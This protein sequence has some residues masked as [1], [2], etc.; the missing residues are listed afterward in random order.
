MSVPTVQSV[1]AE[2]SAMQAGHSSRTALGAARHRAVHQV[3]ERGFIFSDPFALPILGIS[4]DAIIQD[5]QNDEF[6]RK[7]RLFIAIRSR[8]A[9][10]AF[11]TAGPLVERAL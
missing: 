2:D 6:T 4:A 8:L 7:L 11:T 1:L 10:D 3:L 9:E 5:T